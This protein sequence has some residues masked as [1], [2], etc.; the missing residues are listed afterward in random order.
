MKEEA[1]NLEQLKDPSKNGQFQFLL[2]LTIGAIRGWPYAASLESAVWWRDSHATGKEI[3]A[4]T[5][6]L[7]L[8]LQINPDDRGTIEEIAG[9]RWIVGNVRK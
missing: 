3:T 7:R 9:H 8:F 5:D 2:S 1:R 6:F 4:L